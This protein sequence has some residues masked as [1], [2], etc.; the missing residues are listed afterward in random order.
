MSAAKTCVNISSLLPAY[1]IGALSPKHMRDVAEHLEH[2]PACRNQ[3][4]E[5]QL[6]TAAANVAAS[7]PSPSPDVLDRVWATIQAPHVSRQPSRY[8]LLNTMS[9]GHRRL[10]PGQLG[11]RGENRPG[12]RPGYLFR[13]GLA[14]IAQIAV[15]GVI[16]VIL[17]GVLL[18]GG[19]K[20]QLFGQDPAATPTEQAELLA[21]PVVP[22]GELLFTAVL[23]NESTHPGAKLRLGRLTVEAGSSTGLPADESS[24]ILLVEA[25]TLSGLVD[26]PAF[27]NH[28]ADCG[29]AGQS[30]ELAAGEQF[31]L[32]SC[33]RLLIPVG[34]SPLMQ[35]R[36]QEPALAL[37]I[38]MQSPGSSP[39]FSNGTVYQKLADLPA[40]VLP[41]GQVDFSLAEG[42]LSTGAVHEINGPGL[43]YVESG[44]LEIAGANADFDIEVAGD[45]DDDDMNGRDVLNPV[46]QVAGGG[47]FFLR[48]GEHASLT[49]PDG[50][51]R[52]LEM[53]IG[54]RDTVERDP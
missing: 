28:G 45:M 19:W 37:D 16:A 39:R 14:T 18:R 4:F 2:C 33:D 6:I 48:A 1:A 30:Q 52:Y 32:Q 8:N 13:P 49:V 47:W 36:G 53:L 31:E 38:R 54:P 3:V 34:T 51:A 27:V 10:W 41:L 9:G 46:E 26:G 40:N 21:A 43:L 5:W 50:Q 11:A 35:N 22:A 7:G 25:G 42:D 20:E 23:S 44:T 24:V 12:G 15:I 17:G 29:Q